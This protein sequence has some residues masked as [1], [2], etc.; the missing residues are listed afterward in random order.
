LPIGIGRAQS[1][2]MRAGVFGVSSWRLER[3]LADRG[4]LYT[5]EG[6]GRLVRGEAGGYVGAAAGATALA[7]IAELQ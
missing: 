3:A 1:L 2:L 5:T 6:D 4:W 7:L